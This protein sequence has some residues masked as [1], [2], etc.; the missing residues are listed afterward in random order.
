MSL[1]NAT[2]DRLQRENY[3]STGVLTMLTLD[4]SVFVCVLHYALI[5]ENCR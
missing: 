4:R 1:C 3:T 5:E 2:G